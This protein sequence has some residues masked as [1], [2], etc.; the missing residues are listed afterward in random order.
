M[1]LSK[2]QSKPLGFFSYTLKSEVW[3][4][5]KTTSVTWQVHWLLYDSIKAHNKLLMY[6]ELKEDSSVQ[7]LKA[8]F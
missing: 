1:G 7:S 4:V 5:N 8:A 2:H 6:C 3:N